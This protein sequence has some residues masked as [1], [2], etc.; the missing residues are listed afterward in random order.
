MIFMN[1][2]VIQK[3]VVVIAVLIVLGVALIFFAKPQSKSSP[4]LK[5]DTSGQPST[6]KSDAKVHIVVFE[7]LKCIAC[8]IFNTTVLPQIK[9]NYID[10]G[11]ANYTVINV[12][13]IPGSMPAA[14]AARCL[15]QENP[16]WFFTFVDNV[17][18]NQPPESEDWATI[19]RLTQFANVI[20]GVDQ[21]KLSR[22]IYESP[23]T[24]F[25]QK[26]F[27]QAG[28]LQ[29]ATIS[30]PAVYVN[31]RY[32]DPPTVETVSKAIDAAK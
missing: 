9:T 30:T 23:Y 28:K 31:G 19:P 5:I 32:V 26:N 29:G 13:F 22:C 17:Y 10:K 2:S 20:P 27:I 1:K 14:N 12:A 24:D 8:K 16:A 15:Y 3:I 11:I 21:D 6:G 7:D 25:I 18:K 4:V